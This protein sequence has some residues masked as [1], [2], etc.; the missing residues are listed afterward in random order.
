MVR[1]LSQL[2][3]AATAV[4]LNLKDVR[5][6]ECAVACKREGAHSGYYVEK[7]D[8]CACVNFYRYRKLT[9]KEEVR[10]RLE[11]QTT[12]EPE[13]KVIVVDSPKGPWED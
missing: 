5:D 3:I 12:Q 6:A 13:P 7:N 9:R 1:G 2:L 8:L 4:C 11:L 10:N